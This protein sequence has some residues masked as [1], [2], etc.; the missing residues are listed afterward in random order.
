MYNWYNK[1]LGKLKVWNNVN[2]PYNWI[3]NDE[4]QP[5]KMIKKKHQ[6]RMGKEWSIK[7]TKVW[8]KDNIQKRKHRNKGHKR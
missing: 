1:S 8:Y 2:G 6:F 3:Y 4:S 5:K 7:T